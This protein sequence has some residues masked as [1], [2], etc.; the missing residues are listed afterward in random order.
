MLHRSARSIC[1]DKAAL[2]N[3]CPRVVGDGWIRT[4]LDTASCPSYDASIMRKDLMVDVSRSSSPTQVRFFYYF[5][6]GFPDIV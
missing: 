3:S 5:V 4:G 2:A 1:Q 6:V